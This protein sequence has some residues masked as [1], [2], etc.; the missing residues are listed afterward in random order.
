MSMRIQRLRVRNFRNLADIDLQLDPG[1][2]IV[3]ENR[4]G[5][6]N[7]IHALR[8]VLDTSLSIAD[9]QLDRDDFWDGLNDGSE[10]WDPLADGHVIE[11]AIDI[12]GFADNPRVLAALADALLAEDPPRARMTY[13]FGPVDMGDDA[14]PVASRY[15]GRVYGGDNYTRDISTSVRRQL[16]F[17]LLPALRDVESEIARWRGSPLRELLE[18]VAREVPEVDLTRVREAMRSTNDRVNDLD[19]IRDLSGRI[20]TRVTEMVGPYQSV[21]TD[22]AVA[23]DD[24]MRLI[25][26]MRIFVDGPVR[27]RLSSASLGTL[28]IIYLA[29]LDLGLQDRLFEQTIAPLSANLG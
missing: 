22:L 11:V 7:L 21:D 24:P 23:P 17:H 2:V 25:R 13:R 1:S 6:S 28:N 15:Q 5:K 19:Q 27:R 4:S 3:G 26:S 20:T 10:D 12:V 29:L 14:I 18:R 8:L 16:H 9:R